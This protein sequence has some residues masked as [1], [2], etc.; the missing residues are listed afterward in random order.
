[1]RINTMRNKTMKNTSGNPSIPAAGLVLSLLF[2]LPVQAQMLGFNQAIEQARHYD[3]WLERSRLQEQALRERAISAGQLPDPKMRLALA[4]LPTDSLDFNQENMTQLQFGVSQQFPRGDSLQLRQRQAQQ[5]A[6]SGP[7]NRALRQATVTRQVASL[8]LNIYTRQ[9]KI[10]L[11]EQNRALF[12]Q[13]VDVAEANYRNGR[14]ERHDL[15]KAELEL[16]RLEDRITRLRQQR[17]QLRGQLVLWLP[18]ELAGRL[19]PAQRPD[20]QHQPPQVTPAH[21]A[22]VEHPSVQLI[23]QQI[24][25]AETGIKLADQA[26]KP[27]WNISAQY[28]YRDDMDNGRDR[29]D[30]ASV[31]VSFDLPLFPEK[32]Q[33]PQRRAAVNDAQGLRES[34]ELMLRQLHSQ[35][36]AADAGLGQIEARLSLSSQLLSRFDNQRT[37]AMQAYANGTADFTEVMQAAIGELNTRLERVQLHTERQRTLLTLNYLLSPRV[38]SP[39]VAPSSLELSQ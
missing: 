4:N 38:L 26:Y 15:L 34:R 3:N 33:D 13:L 30:F 27:A 12:Q 19:M 7:L 21:H 35:W 20:I 29:A 18:Q 8:W 24:T 6:D 32:R 5:R 1:M 11:I 22:L 23:D 36:R 39:V 17:E 16:T 31:A 37:A 9:A 28:G 14:S 10:R 25:V 2:S